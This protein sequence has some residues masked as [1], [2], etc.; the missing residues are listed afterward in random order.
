M[1]KPSIIYTLLWL[2]IVACNPVK[3]V[4]HRAYSNPNATDYKTFAF[5]ELTKTV[6]VNRANGEQ[7]K[8][9]IKSKIIEEMESRGY[10]LDEENPELLLDL[11]L[12]IRDQ[13]RSNETDSYR[14]SRYGSRR[15]FYHGYGYNYRYPSHYSGEE[16]DTNASM[17]ANITLVLAESGRKKKL[18]EG[19]AEAQMAQRFDKSI[20]RLNEAVEKLLANYEGEG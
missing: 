18:W 9:Y 2:T 17:V 8:E 19:V 13:Q 15:F 16:F 6:K 3:L 20:L 5:E 14:R 11:Q 4:S 12:F 7:V 10:L 1:K